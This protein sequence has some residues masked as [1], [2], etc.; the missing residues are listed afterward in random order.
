MYLWYL[1]WF[2]LIFHL[3]NAET[4]T[5]MMISWS[6]EVLNLVQSLN[7][8][9]TLVLSSAL[10]LALVFWQILQ[11]ITSIHSPQNKP[12]RFLWL[13][14]WKAWSSVT[15]NLVCTVFYFMNFLLGIPLNSL[16]TSKVTP[17][18][19]DGFFSYCKSKQIKIM[20][21]MRAVQL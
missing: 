2:W 21:E 13:P 19:H 1:Q 16:Y 15:C 7:L 11:G 17:S 14:S 5:S 10:L 12:I 9:Y 20:P 8:I 4:R 18:G 6:M 3:W